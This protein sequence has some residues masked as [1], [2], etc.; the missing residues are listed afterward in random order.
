MWLYVPRILS[1]YSFQRWCFVFNNDIVYHMGR[2]YRVSCEHLWAACGKKQHE[3]RLFNIYNAT[4]EETDTWWL[5]L[6]QI[7]PFL[8]IHFFLCSLPHK[9]LIVV[10]ATSASSVSSLQLKCRKLYLNK[11]KITISIVQK[12][13]R[14]PGKT[15]EITEMSKNQH[16]DG[17]EQLD[18]ADPGLRRGIG[19]VLDSMISRGVF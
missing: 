14:F 6:C 17:T 2:I 10:K 9:W 12:W 15:V 8:W 3:G 13:N 4:A 1:R 18:V 19:L 16:G 7:L 11:K 5:S